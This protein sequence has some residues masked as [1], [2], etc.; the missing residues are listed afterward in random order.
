[1]R[2]PSLAFAA[3]LCVAGAVPA[4]AAL[5]GADGLDPAFCKTAASRQTVLYV[6]DMMMIEGRTDWATKLSTKLRATLAPG[7]RVTVVRLSPAAGRSAEI[8]SGCW[9]AYTAAE[10]ARI[11]SQSFLFSRSPLAVLDDQQKFFMRDL[12]A[13][14]GAIYLAGKRPP[15]AVRI[16]AASP[17]DKEILRALASDEGRFAQSQTTIRAIV[18]SDMAES[19]DLGSIFKPA[20]AQPANYGK[21]LGTYLRRSVFY[22]YG[23]GEDVAGAP[24]ALGSA[25][26]FWTQALRSMNASVG[27]LGADLNMANAV[28]VAASAYAVTLT[29]DGQELDGRLA[30]MTDA[31]G[32]LVDSWIG[33]SRLSIAALSGSLHC[34]PEAGCRLNAATNAG[35]ATN[36][37]S[38]MLTLAGPEAGPWTGRLGVKGA[39]TYPV[40]ATKAEN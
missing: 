30:L 5:F 37:P 35:V 8:W 7:E 2:A 34:S 25:R 36:S 12:S 9:P 29:H 31:D 4:R 3:V 13:A 18:Y 23:L 33:V 11:E 10:R 16:D 20:P 6:D 27:G 40:R 32:N 19:S 1:M 14:L 38:E 26:T 21:T 39:L 15:G 28:P 17:P 22:A 24:G